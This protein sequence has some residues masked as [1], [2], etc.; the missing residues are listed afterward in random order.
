MYWP[1]ASQSKH[2]E[3]ESI[4]EGLT[5]SVRRSAQ[6]P[7]DYSFMKNMRKNRGGIQSDT[8]GGA[9]NDSDDAVV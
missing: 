7:P 5:K 6:P 1:K 4:K 9:G 8:E 2:L 3:M